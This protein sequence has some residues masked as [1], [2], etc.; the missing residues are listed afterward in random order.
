MAKP[1]QIAKGLGIGMAIGGAIG[2]VGGVVQQP[3]YQKTAKHTVNKAIKTFN[4]VIDAL[5]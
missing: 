5:S 3:K 2:L 1:A 4:N